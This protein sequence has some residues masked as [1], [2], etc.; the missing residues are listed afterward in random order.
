M[1]HKEKTGVTLILIGTAT[2]GLFPIFVKLGSSQT[3]PITFMALSTL[4]AAICSFFYLALRKEFGFLKNR[5][6]WPLIIYVTIFVVIIPYTLFCLGAARTSNLN[7]SMLLLAEIVFTLIFTHFIGEKTT[8]LKIA[9]SGAIFIGALFLLYKGKIYLNIGDILVI[10]STITYPIGNFFAK[11]AL[12]IIT[13][14]A[15]LFS[16]FLLGGLFML[17]I[18][19]ILEPT[20]GI[21]STLETSWTSIILVGLISLA[22]GKIFYYEALKRLD[23][24]KT[25]SLGMTFPLFSLLVIVLFFKESINLYQGIGV[26]IMMLG[27]YLSVKRPS[28]DPSLTKYSIT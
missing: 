21:K 5:Q 15:I 3:Q 24:S 4:L 18:A 19:T 6:A 17:L 11:K 12:N 27:V 16:R 8:L 22:A 10:L 14:S 1:N 9:G 13:P 2:Y 7:T 26:A 23:I 20:A 25:I 28:V